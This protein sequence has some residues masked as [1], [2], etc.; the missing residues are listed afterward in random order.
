LCS[1]KTER[2]ANMNDV[3]DFEDCKD[4]EEEDNNDESKKYESPLLL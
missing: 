1:K 3:I 4:E 2:E